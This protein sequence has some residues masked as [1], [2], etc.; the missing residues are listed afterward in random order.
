MLMCHHVPSLVPMTA[1]LPAHPPQPLFGSNKCSSRKCTLFY[2]PESDE[3]SKVTAF[4]SCKSILVACTQLH[5]VWTWTILDVLG[6][7]E[8]RCHWKSSRLFYSWGFQS[9]SASDLLYLINTGP[10]PDHIFFEKSN[11]PN[12]MRLIHAH[13]LKTTSLGTTNRQICSFFQEMSFWSCSG[14]A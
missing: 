6:G 10:Y 5:H 1:N 11:L 12:P 2:D 4:P 7:F 13:T 14:V 8:G 9:H 3:A